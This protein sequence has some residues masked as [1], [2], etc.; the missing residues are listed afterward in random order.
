LHKLQHCQGPFGCIH[1]DNF[2][3][4]CLHHGIGTNPP[5]TH[6]RYTL[7]ACTAW[8]FGSSY[9]HHRQGS[10]V[11]GHKTIRLFPFSLQ[12]SIFIIWVFPINIARI[13]QRFGPF[14]HH[15]L[16]TISKYRQ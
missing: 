9:I 8:F 16:D 3:F 11:G 2:I 15:F 10:S 7:D 5:A 4:D 12:D 6:H 14:F 13:N 1:Q